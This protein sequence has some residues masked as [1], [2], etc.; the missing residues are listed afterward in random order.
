MK[1]RGMGKKK[2]E[3][4]IKM[5]L[6]ICSHCRFFRFM[7]K[8]ENKGWADYACYKEK[9]E[10]GFLVG[11]HPLPTWEERDAPNDCPYYVEQCLEKWNG[12]E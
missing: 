8:R 3:E 11:S 4:I 2:K 12:D 5:N 6:N 10:S 7:S 1:E 9:D